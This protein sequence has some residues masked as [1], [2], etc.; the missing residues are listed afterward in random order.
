MTKEDQSSIEESMERTR[1]VRR[2]GANTK[3]K[4]K[5]KNGNGLQDHQKTDRSF[6][7]KKS[8]SP[9]NHKTKSKM[10]HMK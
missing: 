6:V 4:K 5:I 2:P 10:F 1:T 3:H 9:E 7:S 8:E